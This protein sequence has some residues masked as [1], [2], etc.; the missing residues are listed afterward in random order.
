MIRA[1]SCRW[2]DPRSIRNASVPPTPFSSPV[3][4]T[5]AGDRSRARRMTMET[6]PAQAIRSALLASS[7]LLAPTLSTAK[8]TTADAVMPPRLA[9]PPMKPNSRFACRAS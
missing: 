3:A 4:A 2:R 7:R 1:M 9:P 8:T 6:T 5:A